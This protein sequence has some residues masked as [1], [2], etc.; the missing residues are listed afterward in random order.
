[1]SIPAG[2]AHTLGLR[3]DGTVLAV[4]SNQNGVCNVE[5]WRDITAIAAGQYNSLGLKADGTLLVIGRNT[6]KQCSLPE[7]M[8]Q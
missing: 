1:M 5:D 4:G 7:L 6:F 8:N 2:I 3:T